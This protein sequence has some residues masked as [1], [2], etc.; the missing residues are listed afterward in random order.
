MSEKTFRVVT[1]NYLTCRAIN[2]F[3]RPLAKRP[4]ILLLVAVF[5]IA[6]AECANHQETQASGKMGEIDTALQDGPV[7]VEFGAS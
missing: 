1:G 7:F 6:V 2:V 5:V 3:M 4:I